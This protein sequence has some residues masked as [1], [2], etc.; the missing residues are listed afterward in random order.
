MGQEFSYTTRVTIGPRTCREYLEEAVD[1]AARAGA[2][3]LPHFRN[4]PLAENKRSDGGY[5]PV[6][7]ADRAAEEKI[8]EEIEALW[9]GHGIFGEEQGFKPGNGLTWVIDPID[10]T[11]AFMTGMLHWGVLIALFDGESPLLGVMHQPYT[12]EFFV[13]TAD[14]AEHRVGGETTTLG[15]RTCASLADAV[16]C[17]TG[18]QWFRSGAE[19]EAFR[20]VSDSARFT[21][22]GGDCYIYCMLAMGQL[23]LVVEANLKPYDIQALIPIIRGAGGH[24]ATWD[25][26]NPSM[27]GRIV[28][29]G[30]ER[31]LEAACAILGSV[32]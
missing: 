28:A 27:G 9:P 30:D 11:R 14:R 15:V 17:S 19:Q 16:L 18:P 20:A 4:D 13:G 29:A 26:G 5:D 25:G 6:T 7:I 3:I 21:R 12:R 32:E 2:V 23:D 1:L 24:V 31:V 10:G 8:R 22:F